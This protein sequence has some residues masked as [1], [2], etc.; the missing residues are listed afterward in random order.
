MREDDYSSDCSRVRW[1]VR[2][3][4]EDPSSLVHKILV[5]LRVSKQH[6]ETGNKRKE[7]ATVG[8]QMCC[9]VTKWYCV[10]VQTT[11]RALNNE[12]KACPD[13]IGT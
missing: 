3:H 9:T 5:A 12:C 10:Q 6:Q 1:E 8:R 13:G 11:V 7:H 4:V 2:P